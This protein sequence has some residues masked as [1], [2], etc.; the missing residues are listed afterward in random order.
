MSTEPSAAA[1]DAERALKAGHRPPVCAGLCD[2]FRT[3]LAAVVSSSH[4]HIPC[5]MR[6][7]LFRRDPPA[8]S[9]HASGRRLPLRALC[10]LDESVEDFA[11]SD[12]ASSLDS[13]STS[14]NTMHSV[15]AVIGDFRESKLMWYRPGSVSWLTRSDFIYSLLECLPE[16][17]CPCCPVNTISLSTTVSITT[18]EAANLSTYRTDFPR[19]SRIIAFH[20]HISSPHGKTLSV[21]CLPLE[22]MIDPQNY[23][24]RIASRWFMDGTDPLPR[25][26]V[27]VSFLAIG[28]LGDDYSTYSR[29]SKALRKV[30]AYGNLPTAL[31]SAAGNWTAPSSVKV[32]K[33]QRIPPESKP[34]TPV[35]RER[36]PRVRSGGRLYPRRY[37]RKERMT[38]TRAVTTQP[39]PRPSP[40]SSLP[41]TALLPP[42]LPAATARQLTPPPPSTRLSSSRSPA[43]SRHETPL[44]SFP[45]PSPTA[46]TSASVPP[47]LL[48]STFELTRIPCPINPGKRRRIETPG[49][50]RKR[51]RTYSPMRNDL[52]S[53]F[54]ARIQTPTPAT[55]PAIS[56]SNSGNAGSNMESSSNI[57]S[58][59]HF[60]PEL[61]LT[62][63]SRK[64][65]GTGCPKPSFWRI[66]I[67]PPS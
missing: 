51:V 58:L 43:N 54:G 35:Y 47:R 48:V 60:S 4:A 36:R 61:S 6:R 15:V 44:P 19:F 29:V 62:V 38:K 24:C 26:S 13:A 5:L 67:H 9:R 28:V 23:A 16:R 32:R 25:T 66:R 50:N 55:I 65:R 49:E 17:I 63:V 52:A 57:P 7:F 31:L 2:H 14:A 22:L 59:F 40:P 3:P 41:T 30:A 33:Q 18:T 27:G 8:G 1:E 45:L 42:S 11:L 37:Q 39:P 56:V 20:L 21:V 10:E 53:L 34:R 64:R 12:L 46:S